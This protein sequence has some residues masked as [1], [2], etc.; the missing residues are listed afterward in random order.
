MGYEDTLF[1]NVHP[2]LGHALRAVA[3]EHRP[4]PPY[5]LGGPQPFISPVAQA[6]IGIGCAEQMAGWIAPDERE[7]YDRI[8]E[9]AR[10]LF[11]R[12]LAWQREKRHP[13]D[14]VDTNTATRLY[15]LANVGRDRPGLFPLA[16]LAVSALKARA[17]LVGAV[18][19]SSTQRVAR[20]LEEAGRLA[21]LRDFL[22]A[23]DRGI[24]RHECQEAADQHAEAPAPRV[25]R[26]IWRADRGNGRAGHF[27]FTVEGRETYGLITKL[28]GRWRWIDG[29]RDH[30]LASLPDA[31]FEAGT[32]AFFAAAGALATP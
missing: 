17:D 1:H 27:I 21:E 23:L 10:L 26:V 15:R 3:E 30:V 14:V 11:P 13:P 5:H 22:T 18:V 29:D 19:R 7:E 24:V 12:R 9:A 6:A 31:L 25:E 20:A 28:R 32:A 16:P 8:V 2:L 4:P